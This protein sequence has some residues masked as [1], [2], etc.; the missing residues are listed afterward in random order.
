MQYHNS[1]SIIHWLSLNKLIILMSTISFILISCHKPIH[2]KDQIRSIEIETGGGIKRYPVVAIRI[3]SLLTFKYHGGDNAK[4][5]GYYSG[6]VSQGFWDTLNIKLKQINFKKLDTTP[7][8]MLDEERV[9]AIFYWESHKRHIT[10]PIVNNPDSVSDALI[11]I[12]NSYKNVSLHK[13]KDTTAFETP[14]RTQPRP[15]KIN[16]KFPPPAK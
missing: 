15:A 7:Y 1:K 2:P 3:D 14:F 8:D 5:Q 16:I 6:T 4:L 10:K 11:W 9:E 13:T 12:A